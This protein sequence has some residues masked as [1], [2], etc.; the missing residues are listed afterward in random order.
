MTSI[1]RQTATARTAGEV[2]LVNEP[3][4]NVLMLDG[5]GDAAG[6]A[7]D[8]AIAALLAVTYG[9]RYALTAPASAPEAAPAYVELL[10]GDAGASRSGIDWPSH[11]PTA[12][13]A[14]VAQPDALTPAL[15]DRIRQRIHVPLASEVRLERFAEGPAVQVTHR[16]LPLD[17]GDD[18]ERLE[19]FIA[20]HALVPSGRLHQIFLTD[21]RHRA[22]HRA[23]TILRQ[24][25]RQR[26]AAG[27]DR[28][29]AGPAVGVRRCEGQ[30]A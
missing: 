9:C 4:R 8:H 1:E 21:P 5:Y 16:G 23:T 30:R 28:R 12:W 26:S 19:A 10:L 20:E 3:P 2:R 15:V 27:S 29:H 6:G 24:P 7:V 25:V 14:L 11:E 18:L 22:P 13:T 17:A